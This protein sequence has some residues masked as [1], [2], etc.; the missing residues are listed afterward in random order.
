MPQRTRLDVD[1]DRAFQEKFWTFQRVAWALM[2]L[3]LLAALAGTTGSGGPLAHAEASGPG[4][5]IEY[6]RIARWQ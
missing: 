2:A 1:D 6:P 3:I 4:G 5:S